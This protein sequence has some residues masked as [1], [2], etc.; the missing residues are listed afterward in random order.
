M[1]MGADII[2]CFDE[3]APHN[4]SKMYTLNAM[5]RSKRWSK[6]CLKTF[7]EQGNGEQALL[8]VI[9]GSVYE[10][11][12]QS[13]AYFANINNFNGF[14]IGGS[15]GTTQSEMFEVVEMTS[16]M[17]DRSRYIHLLGIG[18]IEDI[19]NGVRCGIDTFDCVSPTRIARHGVAIVKK[20]HS[21]GTGQYR[22]NLNK[23][24]FTEDFSAISPDCDCYTCQ[25]FSKAYIHHLLKA[26]ETLA[27]NLLSIHNIRTM[28]RLMENIR[29]QL[30]NDT[31]EIAKKE[32]CEE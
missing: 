4:V 12:R 16:Q 28:N 5:E 29:E 13:S 25:N 11:Y 10:E 23:S 6:R 24:M 32:W 9:Q 8:A 19:F 20:K 30:K 18:G 31:L 14:A 7:T 26:K 3:C 27:G 21:Y 22:I 2:V 15:L 17:L 1:D